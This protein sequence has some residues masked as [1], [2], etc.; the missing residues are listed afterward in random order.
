MK[1]RCAIVLSKGG[2]NSSEVEDLP[3]IDS[4]DALLVYRRDLAPQV[5]QDILHMKNPN[6]QEYL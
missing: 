6:Q 2:R 1:H 3:I 4:S 5:R